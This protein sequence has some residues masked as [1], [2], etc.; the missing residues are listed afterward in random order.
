MHPPLEAPRTPC[1]PAS[2][3]Q[4]Q[5]SQTNQR[6]SQE[7]PLIPIDPF[8]DIPLQ[9]TPRQLHTALPGSSVAFLFSP[10]HMSTTLTLPPCVFFKHTPFVELEMPITNSPP[11]SPESDLQALVAEGEGLWKELTMAKCKHAELVRACLRPGMCH[12]LVLM[13]L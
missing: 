6:E 5:E 7:S 11:L 12:V 3:P 1:A 9:D 2:T 13:E 4:T 8:L 10:T